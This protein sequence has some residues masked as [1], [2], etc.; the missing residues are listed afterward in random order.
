MSVR[1]SFALLLALSALLFLA[2]CGN[3][4]GGITIG[5]PPP[6]GGFS[7]SNL[8]GTYVF[9]VSGL[10]LNGFP[11]SMV[12]TLT[13]NGSGGITGGGIDINDVGYTPAANASVG[14]SST[15]TVGQDGRGEATISLPANPISGDSIKFDFV[16]QDG[17]HGLITGFNNDYTGSG[18]LDLQTAGVTPSGSYG[19]IFS[20]ADASNQTT[21]N[22]FATVGSFTV[23]S[24]TISGV[25]DFNDNFFAYTDESLSGGIV[26]GPSSTPGTTI[27]TTQFGTQTYDVIA[28]DATHLKFIEMDG[29]VTLSGDAYSQ[30]STSVPTGTLPFTL[31]GP[32][33]SLTSFSAAGGF[34]VTDG[35]GNITDASTADANNGGTVSASP[36]VFTG[37]Y[38][39][40]SAGRY[41]LGLTGFPSGASYAAYTSSAGLL[42]LEIDNLGTM[43]GVAYPAQSTTSFSTSQG[44]ALNL[45]GANL[46]EG[47]EVDDIAEFTADSSGTTVTGVID[48]NDQPTVTGQPIFG[49]ALSGTYTAP[50]SNGR[51]SITATAANGSN[52]TINGGL[53]LTFYTVDGT[54]FPFIETDANGQVASG[55][56]V[57]QAATGS[58]GS[59]ARPHNVY[60]PHPLLHSNKKLNLKPAK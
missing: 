27:T 21:A 11:F 15:Y 6:T 50:D 26:T 8:N 60:V 36:L 54:T 23:S 59:I 13:A 4:G 20:G 32:F 9:S 5:T 17:S 24:G 58:S 7:N 48:E 44:Y 25:E 46:S 22:P 12:G 33:Q 14:G 38:T 34:I 19:F 30:S 18:T 51:G 37:T 35:N 56:F 16:L 45:T 10:D 40:S 53:G 57:E 3:S 29:A 47:V 55:V 43:S 49:V 39:V 41:T 52:T 1:N 42:M 2:A 28:I 31:S